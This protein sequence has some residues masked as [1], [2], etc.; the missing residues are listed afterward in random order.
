MQRKHKVTLLETLERGRTAWSQKNNILQRRIKVR[1]SLTQK[2][3]ALARERDR[4][5]LEITRSM[6]ESETEESQ[7]T[8]R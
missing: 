8:P 2:L 4:L 5:E 6:S 3:E 7:P 1:D